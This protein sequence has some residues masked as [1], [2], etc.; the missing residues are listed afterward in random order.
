MISRN[1][2]L[3]PRATRRIGKGADFEKSLTRGNLEGG[4]SAPAFTNQKFHLEVLA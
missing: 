3:H 1:S 4:V 2:R